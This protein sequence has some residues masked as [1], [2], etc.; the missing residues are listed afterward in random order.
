MFCLSM[1]YVYRFTDGHFRLF[2]YFLL[3]CFSIV[4]FSFLLP[5]SSLSIVLVHY[6]LRFTLLLSIITPTLSIS[7]FL[8]PFHI[9]YTSLSSLPMPPSITV[10]YVCLVFSFSDSLF[11]LYVSFL[12]FSLLIYRVSPP[13]LS[14]SP[15]S[16][17]F[18][19]SDFLFCL[20]FL[21]PLLSVSL[22]SSS[23]LLFRI[24]IFS[25][26]PL[27]LSSSS[28]PA[29]PFRS[30]LLFCLFPFSS[31]PFHTQHKNWG[32]AVRARPH[33]RTHTS[34]RCQVGKATV[35]I[36]VCVLFACA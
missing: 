24:Y 17:H 11:L 26:S 7:L 27:S 15:V 23:C 6:L 31:P 10:F 33:A 34:A 32:G 28:S 12:F 13:R 35:R 16:L 1:S 5:Y 8:L 30:L 21:S 9:L 2:L 18:S 29:S 22:S 4:F 36:C 19:S 3:L 25:S 14:Y 20:D